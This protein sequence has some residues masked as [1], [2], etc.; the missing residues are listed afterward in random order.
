MTDWNK[1]TDFCEIATP[2]GC[3]ELLRDRLGQNFTCEFKQQPD[4]KGRASITVMSEKTKLATVFR[5]GCPED[6]ERITR[7]ARNIAATDGRHREGAME[8]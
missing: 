8:A 4:D 3:I 2:Y 5:I 6:Y 7:L 1:R